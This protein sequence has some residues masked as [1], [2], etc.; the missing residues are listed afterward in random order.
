[1]KY[2]FIAD[3][4]NVGFFILSYLQKHMSID[5]TD[6]VF[7]GRYWDRF[8]HHDNKSIISGY[9][10]KYKSDEIIFRVV[11]NIRG[12]AYNIAKGEDKFDKVILFCREHFED[13]KSMKHILHSN[14][15]YEVVYIHVGEMLFTDLKELSNFLD[16]NK[17]I[18]SCS[19]RNLNHHNFIYSPMLNLI[20]FYYKF[21]FDML[22]IQ[23]NEIKK[24]NLIGGYVTKG[25][26]A[27]RD[28]IY[29]KIENL[30]DNSNI[31]KFLKRYDIFEDSRKPKEM[32]KKFNKDSSP[33]EFQG[34]DRAHYSTFTD[35]QTSVVGF[36]FEGL[37]SIELEGPNRDSAR[38]YITE[39]TLKAILFSNLNVPFIVDMNP[40]DFIM[41]SERGYWFLNSEFFDLNKD[42]SVKDLSLK[43]QKSIEDSVKYVIKL[44]KDNGESLDETHKYF[45]SKYGH[46]M[47]NNYSLFMKELNNPS[48][49]DKMINFL[50]GN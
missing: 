21:G 38:H 31:S 49:S 33:I 27:I 25:N 8:Y 30:F 26:K 29:E 36:L 35:Y 42:Y 23:Y 39:K 17:I 14:D 34:W 32:I 37:D 19:I 40:Y 43:F 13:L 5:D 2:L 28:L 3:V 12:E 9:R 15:D 16:D 45:K 4:K 18:S 41:L 24:S 1:M 6:E 22:N 20:W 11:N 7:K 10:I 47:E 44:F 50:V 46:K 48:D